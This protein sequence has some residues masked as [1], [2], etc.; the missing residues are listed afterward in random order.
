MHHHLLLGLL[1]QLA[2]W[3]SWFPPCPSAVFLHIA[4]RWFLG[5]DVLLFLFSAQVHKWIP[6]LSKICGCCCFCC[7][8]RFPGWGLNPSYSCDLYSSCG[9]ARSLTNSATAKTPGVFLIDS[10]P[11]YHQVPVYYL[12]TLCPPT[13]KD[14]QGQTLGKVMK[15]KFIQFMTTNKQRAEQ[16]PFQSMSR[17]LSILKGWWG[18]RR[19]SNGA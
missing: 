2:H 11:S 16:V 19:G 5:K 12:L 7:T 3:S 15:T 4:I 10:K 9:N 13:I 1:K 6:I 8:W 18:S 17:W 14:K